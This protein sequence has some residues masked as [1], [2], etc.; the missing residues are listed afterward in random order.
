MMRIINKIA[1][2]VYFSL[3]IK[4]G[5]SQDIHFSQNH[6]TPLLL[7]PA[8]T[9]NYIGNW[10]LSNIMRTQWKQ[11]SDPGYQTIAFGYDQKA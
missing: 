11:F 1:L 3:M 5:Y 4:V 10:R 6:L 2:F 9:G 7:N 8:N